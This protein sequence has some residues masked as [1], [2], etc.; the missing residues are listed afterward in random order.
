[1]SSVTLD[2]SNAHLPSATI[3]V[4]SNDLIK[5]RNVPTTFYIFFC[6]YVG[7]FFFCFSWIPNWFCSHSMAV[8]VCVMHVGG[9]WAIC[10]DIFVFWSPHILV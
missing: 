9:A 10:V 7:G 1:M 2:W 8:P 5:K 4:V 6:I 3:M